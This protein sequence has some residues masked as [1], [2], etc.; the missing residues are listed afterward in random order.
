MRIWPKNA[1]HY[2][3]ALDKFSKNKN[4]YKCAPRDNSLRDS[5]PKER[6]LEKAIDLKSYHPT[7]MPPIQRP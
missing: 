3:F 2:V 7:L 4:A 6:V 5:F 1:K